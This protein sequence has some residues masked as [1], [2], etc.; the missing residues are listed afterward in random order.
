MTVMIVLVYQMAMQHWMTAVYAMAVMQMT[1]VVVV[2]KLVLLAVI[3]PVD[4][5]QN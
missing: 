1:L 3:M 5:L 4:Q 2:L